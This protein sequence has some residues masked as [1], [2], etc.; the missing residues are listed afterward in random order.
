MKFHALSKLCTVLF[1]T[2]LL[3]ACSDSKPPVTEPIPTARTSSA[4]SVSTETDIPTTPVS[5]T[6]VTSAETT[7]PS[8]EPVS[9]DPDFFNPM[10][11]LPTLSDLTAQRPI[12][13]SIDNVRKAQPT[14]GVSLADVVLQLP[15]EGYE[16]RLVAV[17]LDYKNLPTVGNIRSARDYSVRYAADFDSILIHAGSDTDVGCRQL[18]LNAIRYGFPVSYLIKKDI[19]Q[20]A[21]ERQDLW[22]DGWD[23]INGLDYYPVPM[24]RDE[25]RYAT[26]AIE[27]TTVIDGAV[28][29]NCISYKNY[30]T[31][32][33]DGF[34]LPYIIGDNQSAS[35]TLQATD[36]LLKYNPYAVTDYGV[37]FVYLPDLGEYEWHEYDDEPHTDGITGENI[38]FKNVIILFVDVQPFQGDAKNRLDVDYVGN[39]DGYYCVNG[40]AEP[41]SWTRSDADAALQIFGADG[42][43]LDIVPGKI[44]INIFAK[45]YKDVCRLPE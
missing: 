45:Q 10:T 22:T 9:S 23:T 43:T 5:E 38:C 35:G 3:A 4:A 26:M 27:H 24:Y 36:I 33:A 7:A 32:T 39:G 8:T 19:I 21:S 12:S 6:T 1:C 37:H 42:K 18:A 41:I 40:K 11:G 31:S 34:T 14:L 2:T 29:Q 17:F 28:I 16:T 20:Y 30:R 15:F 25:Q 44:M 13:I